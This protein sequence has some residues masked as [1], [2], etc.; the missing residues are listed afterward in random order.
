MKFHMCT[1]IVGPYDRND[2]KYSQMWIASLVV[3][4]VR[5]MHTVMLV[6]KL[7]KIEDGSFDHVASQS[8]YNWNFQH[9][10]LVSSFK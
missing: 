7:G 1:F 10:I 5:G 8:K 3:A 9:V 6:R 4:C 2:N